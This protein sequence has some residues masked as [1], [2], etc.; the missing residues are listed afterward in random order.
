VTNRPA[1]ARVTFLLR[2]KLI[3]PVDFRAV[4]AGPALPIGIVALE[5]YPNMN[6]MVFREIVLLGRYGERICQN[7]FD[8]DGRLD[9]KASQPAPV[10]PDDMHRV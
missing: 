3:G 6:D 8:K 10:P 7:R 1:V 2:G 4:D 5:R 9:W